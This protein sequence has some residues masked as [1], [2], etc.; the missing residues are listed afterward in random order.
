MSK[1]I[2][3]NCWLKYTQRMSFLT[4][5]QQFQIISFIVKAKSIRYTFLN[6]ESLKLYI[7][8]KN[9]NWPLK[10]VQNEVG[11]SSFME[12]YKSPFYHWTKWFGL[13][14]TEYVLKTCILFLIRFILSR[15]NAHVHLSTFVS[16]WN[17]WLTIKQW[18]TYTSLKT[19]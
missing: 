7:T 5:F 18:V 11:L 10:I 16:F 14:E 3:G 15:P 19:K 17:I 4:Y 2:K 13:F 9:G 8:R 12:A 1:S 6:N